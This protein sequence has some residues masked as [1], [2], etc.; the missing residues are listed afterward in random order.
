[1]DSMNAAIVSPY[2]RGGVMIS[3]A[4]P[5]ARPSFLS[6]VTSGHS[7]AFC[8]RHVPGV[9]AGQVF[10]QLPYPLSKWHEW[11]KVHVKPEHTA[12]GDGCLYA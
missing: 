2:G 8:Q 6:R 12:E 10:A 9:I 7:S 11:E 1:M 4:G 5:A 3:Q